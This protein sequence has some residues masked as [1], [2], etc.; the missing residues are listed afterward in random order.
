MTGNAASRSGHLFH[1][2]VDKDAEDAACFKQ[3]NV[4][5]YTILYYRP[6]CFL[7]DVLLTLRF[8]PLVPLLAA[9]PFLPAAEV[10]F[11]LLTFLRF[12][13]KNK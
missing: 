12:P 1:H 10:V 8:L 3:R 5:Y 2:L 11:F 4:P 7:L 13:A 6:T 9:F